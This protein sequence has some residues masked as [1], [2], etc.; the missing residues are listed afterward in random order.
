VTAY[1]VLHGDLM[2]FTNGVDLSCD[3]C[4]IQNEFLPGIENSGKD[5]R[6]SNYL[7]TL[8]I[9]QRGG[10]AREGE[11]DE[12]RPH[13]HLPTQAPLIRTV[14][15]ECVAQCPPKRYLLIKK[16]SFPL[17]RFLNFQLR[18]HVFSKIVLN[19]CVST[20]KEDKRPIP[21]HNRTARITSNALRIDDL[22]EAAETVNDFFYV[23]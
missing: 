4:G 19:R 7:H 18:N 16:N 6:N 22:A 2:R 8:Q 9:Q 12:S 11:G 10:G 13:P 1:A 14:S 21:H 17:L 5:L 23:T 3:I 15:K 20:E